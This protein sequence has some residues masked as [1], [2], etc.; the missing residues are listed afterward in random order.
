[1]PLI[2]PYVRIQKNHGSSKGEE[3]RKWGSEG[4]KGKK[5]GEEEAQLKRRDVPSN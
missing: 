2:R 5:G 4:E 1:M 3:K